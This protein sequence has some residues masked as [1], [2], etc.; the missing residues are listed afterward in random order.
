MVRCGL[1]INWMHTKMCTAANFMLKELRKTFLRIR[2]SPM[3]FRF[4]WRWIWRILSSWM[5][6]CAVWW[7]DTSVS[8]EAAG[9][10]ETMVCFFLA[11]QRHTSPKIVIFKFPP[12][13]GFGP[14]TAFSL[15]CLGHIITLFPYHHLFQ[16][17]ECQLDINPKLK[18]F[19][20]LVHEAQITDIP[21]FL[22]CICS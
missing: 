9:S 3:R 13:T 2:N 12:V 15:H 5:W 19:C 6:D 16:L 1:Q 14:W 10:P 22:L 8:M 21:I 17:S 7:K 20:W 11:T 18:I 4:S